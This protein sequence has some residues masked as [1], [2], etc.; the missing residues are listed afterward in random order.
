MKKLLTIFFSLSLLAVLHAQYKY[1]TVLS[2]PV[3]TGMVYTAYRTPAVP[4]TMFVLEVDLKNSNNKIETIKGKDNLVGRE[5]LS[6]MVKRNT[7]P[8]HKV[9]GAVNA[10]FFDLG[11]GTPINIQIS[12]G[13]ILRSPISL[14]TIGFDVNNKPMLARVTMSGTVITKKGNNSINNV[15]AARNTDQL[16]LFNKFKGAATGTNIYGTE[17][18]LNPIDPWAVNDT[19]RCVVAKKVSN[20]GNM[21]FSGEQV[22]LSGHGV[23]QT[24][25]NNNVAEGDTIKVVNKITPGLPKLKEMLGGYPKIVSNGKNYADQ[26]YTEEGGP[27]HAYNREP[28]TAIGFSKDSTKLYLVLVDG[29]STASAGIKLTE[30]AD[31]MISIG[32]SEGMNFDGGGSSEMIIRDQIVNVPSDGAER[33]L[34]NAILVVSTISGEGALKTISLAPSSL[35]I[36]RGDSKKFT[37]EAQDEY[38][39]SVTVDYSKVKFSADPA[40]GAISSDGNFTAVKKAASGYVR[41]EYN[42]LKDSALVI[43]KSLAKLDLQPKHGVAD[44]IKTLKLRLSMYDAD[45]IQYNLGMNE[46]KW[47]VSNPEIGSVDTMGVF[48][49]KKSGTTKVIVGYENIADTAEVTVQTASGIKL[50]DNFES[51]TGWTVTGDNIDLSYSKVSVSSETASLGTTSL[52]IDY[53]FTYDASKVNVIYLNGDIPIYGTPDSIKIDGKSDGQKHFVGYLISD[54]NDETFNLNT[55]KYLEMT[56]AFDTL[57]S[58]FARVAAQSPSGIFDFPA[59]IK[60]IKVKLA[61]PH[62]AGQVYSGTIYLDNLRISYPSAITGVREE[63]NAPLAFNLEQNFP[64][65]FNPSTTIT[66]AMEKEGFAELKIYDVLGRE[67]ESLVKN[68]LG[69]GKHTAVWNASKYTSGVYFYELK[70]NGQRSMKKMIL[71]K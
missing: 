57:R 2:K 55:N 38:Y 58:A 45:Q 60:Q 65:P 64:N 18:L 17:V 26:G 11:T 8:G 44:N 37:L 51:A 34:A 16:I 66:F 20:A 30:L 61:S 36:F 23:A 13:H 27:D 40:I 10:D 71:V 7:A 4:W 68:N 67:V 24:F 63:V 21:A 62:V 32:V 43:V 15:N 56:T 19:I 70:L 12:G 42:G 39:N 29:R 3:S 25:L 69:S 14:S 52:K 53:K 59:R 1:D 33:P 22:V 50:L 28:R 47:S 49:G 35:K 6:S 31:F 54:E 46:F 5:T 48:S 41:A 9:I